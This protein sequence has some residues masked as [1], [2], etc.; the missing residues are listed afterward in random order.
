LPQIPFQLAQLQLRKTPAQRLTGWGNSITEAEDHALQQALQW[1]VKAPQ[2]QHAGFDPV[3]SGWQLRARQWLLQGW[4][5]LQAQS[6]ILD[7][8]E[9]RQLHQLLNMWRIYHAQMPEV[10]YIALPDGL[11]ALRTATTETNHYR[12]AFGKDKT[13]VLQE[14]LAQLLVP[15]QLGEF[16]DTQ[17]HAAVI[18]PDIA[19]TEQS[20]L[21]SAL[22]FSPIDVAA[23]AASVAGTTTVPATG[24]LAGTGIWLTG[25]DVSLAQ[26]VSNAA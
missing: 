19:T 25:C 9:D 11:L 22:P 21:W 8:I 13:A 15:L 17:P 20:L 5:T 10:H 16:A 2:T 7:R 23:T 1:L 6:I 18:Y 24:K 12:Y 3:Q 14:L 4:Q 26:E